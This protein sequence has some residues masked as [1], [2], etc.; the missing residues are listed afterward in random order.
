MLRLSEEK[1]SKSI[2]SSP[3]VNSL[4]QELALAEERERCRIADE[5]HDQL[6]PNLLV[7]MMKLNSLRDNLTLDSEDET[8]GYIEKLLSDAIQD[9]RSLTFQ[10]RPPVLANAGLTAA[11]KWLANEFSEKYSLNVSIEDSNSWHLLDFALRSTLFQVVRELLLNVAKHARTGDARLSIS[12]QMDQV[13]ICVED[14]GIGFDAESAAVSTAGSGFGLFNIR[15]KIEHLG[16]VL[17]FDSAPGCGTKAIVTVPAASV[18]K[19]MELS[20]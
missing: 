15:Q 9:I 5:L 18:D 11:L 16:G 10:L 1:F 2:R 12:R 6:A 19:N 3:D 17:Q 7:C 14:D 8:V 4:V 13:V 20:S